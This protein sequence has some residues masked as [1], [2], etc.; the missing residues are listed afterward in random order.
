MVATG[1]HN[2]GAQI[3]YALLCP[4]SFRE[5]KRERRERVR[6]GGRERGGISFRKDDEGKVEDDDDVDPRGTTAQNYRLAPA[7]A[8]SRS[9]RERSAGV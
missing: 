7:E 1:Q 8:S 6:K 2:V 9:Q 5:E 3:G 4:S